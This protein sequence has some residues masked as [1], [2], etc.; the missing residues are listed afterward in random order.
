M[1]IPNKSYVM[2]A[3]QRDGPQRRSHLWYLWIHNPEPNSRTLVASSSDVSPAPLATS[4]PEVI[5]MSSA[6]L[7]EKGRASVT[8]ILRS[9]QLQQSNATV[10]SER[11]VNLDPRFTA[12]QKSLSS[13]EKDLKMTIQEA[14]H[15][16]R[17][18]QVRDGEFEQ[19]RKSRELRWQS[20]ARAIARLVMPKEL[21]DLEGRNVSKVYPVVPS[22]FFIVRSDTARFYIGEVLDI[23]KKGANS[24]YGSV[25]SADSL[26]DVAFLSLHVYLSLSSENS[27]ETV[28]EDDD[29]EDS[30]PRFS[31]R[32]HSYH[33]HTHAPVHHALYHLGQTAFQGSDQ[34]A[35][36]LTP[37]AG[38]HWRALTQPTV[39]QKLL[40]LRIGGGKVTIV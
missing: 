4:E 10:R 40:K 15:R 7:D 1:T 22:S 16:V 23:Y 24:R 36:Q 26:S 35:L 17:I 33:L 13:F 20:C 8:L 6:I 27:D 9:R 29:P 31:M 34:R 25:D 5:P 28:Y 38:K 21:P 37:E 12:V 32:Y 14:S 30:L 2:A 11:V 3:H 18:A 39:K 19:A